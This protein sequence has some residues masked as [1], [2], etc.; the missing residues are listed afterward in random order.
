MAAHIGIAAC[1]A[2]GAALCYRTICAEGARR[3]GEHAHPE[4]S[5]HTPSFA[6]YVHCLGSSWTSWLPAYSMLE[7]STIA[8]P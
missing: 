7:A 6:D 1:S 5:V 4:V 8:S 2:E 3:L